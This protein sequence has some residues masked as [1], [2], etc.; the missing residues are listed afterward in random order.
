[1]FRPNE[2]HHAIFYKIQNLVQCSGSNT[3][4]TNNIIKLKYTLLCPAETRICLYFFFYVTVRL[5][6]W[7]RKGDSSQ[8]NLQAFLL[9]VY[10]KANIST[11]CCRKE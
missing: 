5:K 4:N 11:K 7:A 10:W 3:I 2:Y 8:Q 9:H 6:T 1:M